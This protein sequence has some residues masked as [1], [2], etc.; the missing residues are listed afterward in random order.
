M[1]SAVA[2]W[3]CSIVDVS[4]QD[5]A[6]ICHCLWFGG[7]CLG[8]RMQLASGLQFICVRIR[9]VWLGG[10]RAPMA[11]LRMP[12]FWRCM[13][14]VVVAGR[15]SVCHVLWWPSWLLLMGKRRHTPGNSCCGV[16]TRY[17]QVVALWSKWLLVWRGG[18]SSSAS[19]CRVSSGRFPVGFVLIGCLNAESAY[20]RLLAFGGR[21]FDV[22]C[23]CA[24]TVVYRL[25]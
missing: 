6:Q 25:G 17:A 12:A 20:A 2:V 18:A 13:S 1:C 16:D 23:R 8:R 4:L 21:T 7:A 3:A 15:S 22:L 11:H 9:R 19:D 5:C 14:L 10:A 24:R